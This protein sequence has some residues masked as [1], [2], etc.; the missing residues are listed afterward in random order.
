MRKTLLLLII[1]VSIFSVN[2]TAYSA[3][4]LPYSG[5][6]P[7]PHGGYSI[8]SNKCKICHAIHGTPENSLHLL[9]KAVTNVDWGG[10]EQCH[11]EASSFAAPTVY[12]MPS[13]RG[14]HRIDGSALV[15]PDSD[16]NLPVI[17]YTPGLE[18]HEE[19]LQKYAPK[20]SYKADGTASQPLRCLHC[21]SPHGNNVMGG[22]KILRWDPARD[23][24]MAQTLSQ[25]C[26]DCHNRNYVLSSNGRSH[27]LKAPGRKNIAYS[28]ATACVACH[29]AARSIDGGQF[30]HQSVGTSL[31]KAQYNGKN[32][33]TVCLDCH[34]SSDGKKGVGITF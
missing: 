31:L 4:Y 23:G 1:L 20:I 26:G 5:E 10:C 15:I 13:V 6:G 17:G 3:G 29:R 2:Q 18:A 19:S 7:I 27:P 11:S 8:S 33:T 32:I 24:G 34:R 30:P 12:S 21:H 16:K 25:F 9:P 22:S 14:E 28:P